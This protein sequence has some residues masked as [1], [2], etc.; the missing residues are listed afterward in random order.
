V[1]TLELTEKV[2]LFLGNLDILHHT[3]AKGSHHSKENPV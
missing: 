1:N 2:P 3:L